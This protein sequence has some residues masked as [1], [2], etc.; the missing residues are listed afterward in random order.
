MPAACPSS[1]FLSAPCDGPRHTVHPKGHTAR[2][3]GRV[4][5]GP[6]I[7]AQLGLGLLTPVPG[8][9]A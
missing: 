2:L 3:A 9:A 8:R 1:S 4:K 5:A 7:R 6:G